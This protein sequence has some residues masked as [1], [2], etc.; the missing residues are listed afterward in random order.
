MSRHRAIAI[1]T[2]LGA[3]LA[4]CNRSP[5]AAGQPADD[6]NTV[7]TI[8]APASTDAL[9]QRA[10][11][12]MREQR[13]FV[14]AG[15]NA[16][17]YYLAV[18]R[19]DPGDA[20]VRAGLVDLQPLLIIAIEQ[21]IASGA[22]PEGQRLV[23]HLKEMDANAPALGRLLAT[24]A[25]AQ[26]LAVARAQAVDDD[27]KAKAEA[28]VAAL[29]QQAELNAQRLA[30]ERAAP[31]TASPANTASLPAV[32]AATP[33]AAPAPQ[34]QAA[35]APAPVQ[36]RPQPVAATPSPPPTEPPRTAAAQPPRQ[37]RVV[38]PVYPPTERTRGLAGQVQVAFTIG[39]DGDVEE[40]RVVA[41]TLPNVFGRAA[42]SAV[43]RWKFEAS[44][45]RH[46]SQRTLVFSPAGS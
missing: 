46:S 20:G 29:R 17:E 1:A 10:E 35:P 14:P 37:L 41:S 24:V 38:A 23:R 40:P 11:R 39:A 12:A 4:A 26:G 30:A 34:R 32:V 21:A 28:D 31:A 27:A 2:L 44:G 45:S 13:L 18:Q 7:T 15:D 9:R 25:D 42:L 43:A 8:N 19:Q 3:L 33:A 5:P 36:T 16:L 22:L 6:G